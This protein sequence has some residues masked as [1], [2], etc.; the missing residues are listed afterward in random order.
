MIIKVGDVDNRLRVSM[1]SVVIINN[2]VLQIHV[3]S[4][5]H[6]SIIIREITLKS[7]DILPEPNRERC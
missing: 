3:K 5:L 2:D 1:V 6:F 7:F 4:L